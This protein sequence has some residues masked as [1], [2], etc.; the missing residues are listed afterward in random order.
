MAHT[1]AVHQGKKKKGFPHF[2]LFIVSKA[3]AH[4]A[5][6]LGIRNKR[7]FETFF[8][9]LYSNM[10]FTATVPRFSMN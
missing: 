2:C 4:Q 8:F 9:F 5:V 1:V 6:G 7:T 10:F 3:S